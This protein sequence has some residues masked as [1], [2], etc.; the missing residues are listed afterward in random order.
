M[1]AIQCAFQRMVAV[2]RRLDEHGSLPKNLSD[3]LAG[4]AQCVSNGPCTDATPGWPLIGSDYHQ[5]SCYKQ[6]TLLLLVK[7]SSNCDTDSDFKRDA[8]L[9]YLSLLVSHLRMCGYPE[10]AVTKGEEPHQPMTDGII[11]KRKKT[12]DGKSWVV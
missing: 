10:V 11:D 7:Q 9:R 5:W 6:C 1:E 2:S 3:A 12:E 8:L 4:L